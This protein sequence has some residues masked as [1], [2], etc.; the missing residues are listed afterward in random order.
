VRLASFG[1]PF[2]LER[3]RDEEGARAVMGALAALLPPELRGPY[4]EA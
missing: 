1:A 4:G 2:T 3:A